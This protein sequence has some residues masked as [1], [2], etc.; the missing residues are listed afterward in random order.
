MVNITEKIKEYV[1]MRVS[2]PE[3]TAHSIAGSRRR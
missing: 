3:A 2:E 1:D